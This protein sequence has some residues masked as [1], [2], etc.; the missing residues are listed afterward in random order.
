M[1]PSTRQL[2]VRARHADGHRR[3]QRRGKT[4]YFNLIS[5]QLP[6]SAG[7][8]QLDGRGTLSACRP[9]RAPAPGW[10]A[11]QLTNLFPNLSVR[12][13]VRLAV[14][15]TLDGATAAPEPVEHL[16]DHMP[17]RRARRRDPAG[18]KAGASARTPPWPA[19]RTA[20]SASS[21][22]PC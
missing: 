22:S 7:S 3:A 5:G 9:R 2:R 1:W 8:V 16:G 12:E 17:T 4:T 19:C 15:A 13:N 6:A 10:G 20:T 14:Q 11:F 18:G 21:R